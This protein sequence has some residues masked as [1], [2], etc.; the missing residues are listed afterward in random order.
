MRQFKSIP[1]E[2]RDNLAPTLAQRINQ[3]RTLRNMTVKD[4]AKACRFTTQRVE[5]LESGLELWLSATDRQLLAN[6]LAIEPQVLLDVEAKST[7]NQVKESA[8]YN[9]QKAR[10]IKEDILEGEKNIECPNCGGIL[11]CSIQDGLDIE[12]RPII[13]AKAFCLK[14]PWVL[15]EI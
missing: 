13:F 7:T 3:L 5:D 8:A 11:K 9:Q 12:G 15:K 14:C 2:I 10:A 4:V 6:A 1:A